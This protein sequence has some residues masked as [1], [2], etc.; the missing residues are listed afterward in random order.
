MT[1]DDGRPP[2]AGVCGYP[3]AQSKSPLLFRHWFTEHG[4]TG[5]YVP[6]LIE[7]GSFETVLP[8]LFKAGFRGVN[9][10]L[11]HK[12]TALALADEVSD[13]AQAIGAANTITFDPDGRIQ[14]DNTDGFGF[15]SNVAAGA[16]D[17]DPSTG[18]A[19][20]LGAG[21]AARAAIHELL[22]GGT[23]EIRLAN[24]TRDRAEALADHFGDRI[25]VVDWSERCTA[26]DGAVTIAN[27]TS[28]GMTGK[29]PLEIS[30]DAAPANAVVTDMVYNPLETDLLAQARARGL[31][32]VDGLGM[33]LHQARPGFE[34]WFGPRPQVNDALRAACLGTD[35]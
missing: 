6:L 34:R 21:G 10:T 24:R 26:A 1:T 23:P 4:M 7:P 14:A 35:P 8:T 3:I 32:T 22:R 18:P 25:T 33:L 5:Y 17:W 30:L 13:A 16:P 2:L 11:P 27:S 12:E 28:L 29:P 31:A 20:L 9:V 15:F 19:L